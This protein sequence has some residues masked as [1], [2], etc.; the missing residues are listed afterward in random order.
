LG[1]VDADATRGEERDGPRGEEGVDRLGQ[2]EVGSAS[3]LALASPVVP[4][5]E[6]GFFGE[7]VDESYPETSAGRVFQCPYDRYQVI[8]LAGVDGSDK[9]QSNL[10]PT[11]PDSTRPHNSPIILIDIMA[12]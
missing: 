1:G 5:R 11:A 12:N 3:G 2:V 8:P 6:D 4:G 9:P 10:R 7:I